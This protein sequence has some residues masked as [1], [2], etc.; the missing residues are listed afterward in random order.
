MNKTLIKIQDMCHFF[1]VSVSQC[2]YSLGSNAPSAQMSGSLAQLI[3]RIS[4][5]AR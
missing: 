4:R 1:L 2:K 3:S 5:N